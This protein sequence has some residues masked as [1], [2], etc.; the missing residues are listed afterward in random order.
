MN[1]GKLTTPSSPLQVRDLQKYDPVMPEML[2]TALCPCG[3]EINPRQLR[4][5]YLQYPGKK[6][7]K[8]Q[9]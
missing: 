6:D 7:Q 3:Q 5:Y 4:D 8:W 9:V 1:G 2:A